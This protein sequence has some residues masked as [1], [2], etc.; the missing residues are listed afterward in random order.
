MIADD[1]E[2]EKV[3]PVV[4]VDRMDV[5]AKLLCATA[6]HNVDIDTLVAVGNLYVLQVPGVGPVNVL[7]DITVRLWQCYVRQAWTML[8]DGWTLVK[9]EG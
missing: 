4:D 9:R 8:E 2:V 6:H 3:V 7:P 5:L 1:I